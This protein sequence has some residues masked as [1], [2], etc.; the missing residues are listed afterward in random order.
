MKPKYV[1]IMSNS[2]HRESC[3]RKA[4]IERYLGFQSISVRNEKK[5]AVS[6]KLS[7]RRVF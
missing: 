6:F 3:S 7:R 4:S 2:G 5:H 1:L